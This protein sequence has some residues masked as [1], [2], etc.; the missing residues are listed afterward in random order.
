[1]LCVLHVNCAIICD[2]LA[3]RS[4]LTSF[5][6][7]ATH[8]H[9]RTLITPY[10]SLPSLSTP[11]PSLSSIYALSFSLL[12]LR[13]FRLSSLFTP[14]QELPCLLLLHL[15]AVHALF[16]L[17]LFTSFAGVSRPLTTPHC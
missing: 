17:G 14:F 2:L 5:H 10:L 7:I 9:H 8:L 16:T 3:K 1:M 4:L 11:F 12:Y 15:Q 6:L 13:P